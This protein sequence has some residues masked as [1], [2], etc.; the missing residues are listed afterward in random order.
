MPVAALSFLR[1]ASARRVYWWWF[2]C[3][4]CGASGSLCGRLYGS[5]GV[6][7]LEGSQHL[8][9]TGLLEGL[10]VMDFVW[11]YVLL[12]LFGVV[13]FVGTFLFAEWDARRCARRGRPGDAVNGK[14]GMITGVGVHSWRACRGGTYY[15]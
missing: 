13:I 8:L 7:Y 3:R 9:F 4:P 11:Y 1:G 6:G 14:L 15:F 5:I 2:C 12:V 10:P